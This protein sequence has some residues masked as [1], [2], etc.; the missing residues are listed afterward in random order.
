MLL[1]LLLAPKLGFHLWRGSRDAG[2]FLPV[3]EAAF[4]CL[5][6]VPLQA[7]P[8]RALGAETAVSGNSSS[9]ERSCWP[10]WKWQ[11][12]WWF[13]FSTWETTHLVP[14]WLAPPSSPSASPLSCLDRIALE[15][16]SA[17]PPNLPLAFSATLF[18]KLS[19]LPIA[20]S[21]AFQTA[22]GLRC[23]CS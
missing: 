9:F 13:L 17:P 18:R 10:G 4:L 1:S 14:S 11:W 7:T 2:W 19:W 12:G 6:M 23:A 20:Y 16:I 21:G 22:V 5:Q 8:A 15:L 3:G